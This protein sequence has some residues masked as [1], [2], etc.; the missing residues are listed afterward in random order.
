MMIGG[1]LMVQSYK[2]E[3]SYDLNYI[4]LEKR[5]AFAKKF[6]LNQVDLSYSDTESKM[7]FLFSALFALSEMQKAAL[8]L[9][10]G[11]GLYDTGDNE[12]GVFGG[13]MYHKMMSEKLAIFLMPRLHMIF[14]DD[15]FMLLQIMVGVH[16]WLG[17]PPVFG[18]A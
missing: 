14:A 16:F 17:V 11:G 15:S 12:I 4:P 13:L 6:D 7:N 9:N 8:F 5:N 2:W 10:F 1:E 3:A 18:E